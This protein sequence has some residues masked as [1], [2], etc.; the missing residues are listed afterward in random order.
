M[1]LPGIISEQSIAQ[2][3]AWLHV[4]DPRTLTAGIG[5]DPGRETPLA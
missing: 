5:I 1:T 2:G 3:G 4:P